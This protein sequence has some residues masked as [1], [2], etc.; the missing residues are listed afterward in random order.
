MPSAS[1]DLEYVSHAT[2]MI[3]GDDLDPTFVSRSL[4]L[5]PSQSWRRGEP[6]SIRG[7]SLESTASWGGWKKFLPP[8]QKPRPLPSQLRYWVRTLRGR[9]RA[10]AKL[11]ASGYWCSLDCYVGSDTTASLVLPVDLQ[12]SLG[13]LGLD[14]RISVSVHGG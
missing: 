6:Q 14:V 12:R 10:L 5:R 4:K 13:V 1:D 8:S 2:L 3:L 9:E 11:A 7:V